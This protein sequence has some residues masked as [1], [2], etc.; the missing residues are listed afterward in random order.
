MVLVSLEELP[1]GLAGVILGAILDQ[2]NGSGELGQQ[3]EKKD[4]ITVAVE[5]IFQ[6]LVDQPTAEELNHTEHFV[7]FAQ[8]GGF[9]LWLLA[10]GCPGVGQGTPQGKTGFVAKEDGCP[11]FPGLGQDFRPLFLHPVLTGF[12]V[13]MVRD[14]ASL[15]ARKAQV[16]Q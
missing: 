9:D 11:D 6:A 2:D 5:A 13:Q 15:L 3:V 14:K 16:M 10:D 1:S 12:F 8:A 4:L 7:P